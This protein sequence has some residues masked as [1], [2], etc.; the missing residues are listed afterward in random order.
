MLKIAKNGLILHQV[1]SFGF[2]LIFFTSPPPPSDFIPVRDRQGPQVLS[3]P[4]HQ[5]FRE[6]TLPLPPPPENVDAGTTTEYYGWK[7]NQKVRPRDSQEL[8]PTHEV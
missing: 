2:S 8:N 5:E 3:P 1:G 6:K 7:L 4:P